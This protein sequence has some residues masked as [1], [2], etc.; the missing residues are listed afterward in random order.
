MVHNSLDIALG[1]R[2]GRCRK[3]RLLPLGYSNV[4]LLPSLVDA[5]LAPPPGAQP[6]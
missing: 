2:P 4:V 1:R 3:H 5:V 6:T